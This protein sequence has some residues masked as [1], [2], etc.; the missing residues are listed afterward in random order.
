[1]LLPLIL[2]LTPGLAVAGGET[3]T[4]VGAVRLTADSLSY[5]QQA[6]SLQAAGSVNIRWNRTTLTSDRARV[7]QRENVATAEGNVILRRNGDVLKSDRI[8]INYQNESGEVENGDLFSSARNF[9]LRGR[10][11]SK[12]GETRYHL[13]QGAFTTCD[14]ASPSWQFTATDLDVTLEGYAVGK[15]ALFYVGP[16]PVFYTPYILFPVLTERQS[17]FLFPRIGTSEK[18]GFNFD[19]PFYWAISPSQDVTFDLDLETKRGVGFGADY[20][21]LGRD[22]SHGTMRLFHIYDTNRNQSR[23]DLAARQ[24]L[25]FTQSVT[26][27]NDLHL[28]LDRDF[29]RDYGEASGDYNRQLLDSSLAVSGHWQ[30]AAITAEARYIED[31]YAANNHGTLQRL[32]DLS[33]GLISRR[34]YSLPV[35]FSLDSEFIHFQRDV[36]AKGERIDLHPGLT[37]FWPQSGF[38][39]ASV[40][41]GYRQ[42]LY[43]VYRGSTG[44]GTHG[45]GNLEAGGLVSAPLAR[46]YDV[47]WG[48]M[49]RL[50]HSIIPEVAIDYVQSRGQ[51]GLPFFDYDDRIVGGSI[52]TL[53]LANYLAG[54][55]QRDDAVPE[56]RDLLFLKLSQGYQLS[57]S[58]RDLL[59][60]VD[61]GRSL[62]DLRLETR[63]L[64]HKHVSLATDS[65]YDTY[66]SRFSSAS[67]TVEA[68]DGKGNSVGAG[69]RNIRPGFDNDGTFRDGVDYFEGR[70]GLSIVKPFD[71]HYTGRHSFDKGAFLES[72]YTLEYKRQCWSVVFSYRDRPDERE[73]LVSFN[74]MG[75]GALGRV[76]AF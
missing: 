58:R 59:N 51:E 4:T 70:L 21:Y 6:D 62:T 67:L 50:Q 52:V 28:S 15:N 69:Y 57:G 31:L 18:K 64:P 9:H 53:S 48:D 25:E 7:Q 39:Q 56:S 29:Y 68:N 8:R 73:F 20:R 47:S 14:G 71:F 11:F 3:L 75:I 23:G 32:P 45:I 60:L 17:G 34:I 10:K 49:R 44:N 35:Y 27:T 65:R 74:L 72:Y 37:V 61:R 19:L 46:V 24:W 76:K 66:R 43:E 5:D 12:T 22:G 26:F 30:G 38:M 55:V 40:R 42:R 16:L 1:L 13:E 41:G 54:R 2:F 36:G 63:F 33:A